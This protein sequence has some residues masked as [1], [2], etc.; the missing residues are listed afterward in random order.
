MCIYI[1]T[2]LIYDMTHVFPALDLFFHTFASR[3]LAFPCKERGFKAPLNIF[4]FQELQRLQNII[5][6][7]RSNLDNLVLAIEGVVVMTVDL[8]EDSNCVFAACFDKP[9]R[10]RVSQMTLGMVFP[11]NHH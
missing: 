5:F 9:V 3:K 10:K 4:L 1:Y 11:L 7:V 2:H 6:I 8:L